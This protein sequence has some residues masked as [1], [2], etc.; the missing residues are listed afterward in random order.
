MIKVTGITKT[1]RNGNPQSYLRFRGT[2]F[3]VKRDITIRATY[4]KT[5][6]QSL[7]LLIGR[8]E[9]HLSVGEVPPPDVMK[10]VS[11]IREPKFVDVLR[12]LSLLDEVTPK[13][14]TI[15]TFVGQCLDNDKQRCQDGIIEKSTLTKRRNAIKK[16]VREY[17]DTYDIRRLD[18]A[19][20][21]AYA[22]KRI[23]M[24]SRSLVSGEIK[25]L[26]MYF[27]DAVK[28][29]IVTVNP[30]EG[31]MVELDHDKIESKR[32]VINNDDLI[33]VESWLQA[34]RPDD[35]YVYW[36]VLRWTGCR[37]NE[38]LHLKWSD[39]D[40]DGA[41]GIGTIKMPSPKTR[42]KHK[43]A[44]LMPMFVGTPLREVLLAEFERQGRPAHGYV[45][46]GVCALKDYDRTKTNWDQCNPNTNLKRLI[47]KA[48]VAPW[49]KTCQNVRV[50]RENELLL[51]GEYRPEAVHAFIGHTRKTFE[52]SYASMTDQDML[53]KSVRNQAALSPTL[54][55]AGDSP[56]DS[57]PMPR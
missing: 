5:V 57:P 40:F 44:R 22:N 33:A 23:K 50:T 14:Y 8:M 18:Y 43:P 53:P 47:R 46:R 55:E 16:F 27:R 42:K 39:I 1:D 51:S 31:V 41:G 25:I 11:A 49:I 30:F 48:G 20:L 45:V 54:K 52:S 37:K 19:M 38:P 9:A 6:V 7:E 36:I 10:Q 34:N 29:G 26:R 56:D 17:G 3:G 2:L 12:R 35:Y 4:R 24:H 28:K 21:Q 15:G 13:D 32:I